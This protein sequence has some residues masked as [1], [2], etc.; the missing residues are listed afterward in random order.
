DSVNLFAAVAD[1]ARALAADGK[2]VLFASWSEGSSE[3][4][5]VMLGDHGLGEVRLAPYWAAARA[6]DPRRPQRAVLPVEQGLVTDNLARISET[7]ILGDRRA[8]PRRK[9]RAA[10]FLAEASALSAGDLVVHIDHGI[11]RYAG[12]K[13]LEVQEAP[14]CCLELH[15]GAEAKLYLPVE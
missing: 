9:R 10:N 7:A 12:L 6:A 14:H 15:Y 13:T 2:R 1:H 3:R 4:R 11:A 5:G 8:R